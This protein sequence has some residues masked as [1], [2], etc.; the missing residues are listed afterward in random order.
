MLRRTFIPPLAILRKVILSKE[1]RTFIRKLNFDFF[2]LEPFEVHFFCNLGPARTD[3][4]LQLVNNFGSNW[5]L[6]RALKFSRLRFKTYHWQL[7]PSKGGWGSAFSRLFDKVSDKCF[8]KRC[9]FWPRKF[10]IFILWLY[11]RS[12]K[13]WMKG[14]V[15]IM[16]IYSNIFIIISL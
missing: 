16:K 6:L 12:R 15:W 5:L 14:D 10:K 11:L 7:Q 2:L 3:P 1:F 8:C 4:C 9:L 13:G